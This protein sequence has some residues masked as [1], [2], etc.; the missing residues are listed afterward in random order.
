MRGAIEKVQRVRLMI[1]KSLI[2]NHKIFY[3]FYV[4]LL[5]ESSVFLFLQF[6]KHRIW[7]FFFFLQML[8]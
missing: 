7:D 6:V 5:Q 8:A 4:V 1:L 3:R 2:L